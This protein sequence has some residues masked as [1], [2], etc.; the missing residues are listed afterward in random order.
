M[1]K[2]LSN[3]R[4]SIILLLGVIIGAIAGFVMGPKAEALK[5][6]ADIF[7]N[8]VFCLIVPIV[9][10]SIASSI[11]NM[12]NVGKLKKVLLIFLV[13]VIASGVITSVFALATTSIFPPTNGDSVNIGTSGEKIKSNLNI[14]NMLTVSDFSQLL[15][16]DN[17]LPLIIFSIMFGI[18][19]SLLGSKAV[20]IKKLLNNT[21]DVLTKMVEMVMK[22]APL[23][24]ACYFASMIGKMGGQ[25]VSSI[26]RISL[27]Y[28]V[29]CVLFFVLTST[30]YTYWGGGIK[31]VKAYWRN[32]TLPMTTAM[33]TC[34]S[35][36]CIPVNLL[37][38]EKMG[39]PKYICDIV[40]PLGGSTHKNGVVSVQI[41]KIAFLF[42]V[43]E[44]SFGMKEMLTAIF[45]AVISG[46]IVGTIPSGGFIGEMFICTALGFPTDAIPIIVIMGTLTDP[47][48]T[49]VNVT[50]DPAISMVIARLMEGKD[51]VKEKL[52]RNVKAK[53]L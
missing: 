28:V 18:G 3:Y 5:P 6:I 17:M 48:C 20:Q 50:S 23:G 21:T 47:F 10:T 45:V 51:W 16:K 30:L 44:R 7:L 4:F 26:A 1:M 42:A 9:F 8:L 41:M 46:I 27:I 24:I 25:V 49:M 13:V 15:S 33:G 35:T 36:A 43:F 19:V 38:S 37:A 2:V 29:F 11:A 40:I 12:E 34:S 52:P 31:G 53:E 14:V 39:I 32:I 22:L